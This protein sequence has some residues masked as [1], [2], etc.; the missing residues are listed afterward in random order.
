[1][2]G[3]SLPRDQCA[4]DGNEVPMKCLWQWLVVGCL[5]PMGGDRGATGKEKGEFNQA[6]LQMYVVA[7]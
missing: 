7:S 3:L 6:P 5:V 4:V 1:M 2:P